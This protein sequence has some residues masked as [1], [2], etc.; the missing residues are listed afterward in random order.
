MAQGH[1]GPV[2]KIHDKQ[3]NLV[4]IKFINSR[5]RSRPKFHLL[6][7]FSSD[8]VE[9]FAVEEATT[10]SLEITIRFCWCRVSFN[11]VV[12]ESSSLEGQWAL[13]CTVFVGVIYFSCKTNWNYMNQLKLLSVRCRFRFKLAIVS[14][15]WMSLKCW[16]HFK[17]AI[18][19]LKALLQNY[20]QPKFDFVLGSKSLS[21]HSLGWLP[22]SLYRHLLS[23]P[24]Q[25]LRDC[26]LLP[27]ILSPICCCGVKLLLNELSFRST[28]VL[29]FSANF[30]FEGKCLS[31]INTYNNGNTKLKEPFVVGH[32]LFLAGYSGSPLSS[33]SS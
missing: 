28:K 26:W 8:Q 14:V 30:N 23:F 19:N 31:T 33:G 24:V 12:V 13:I 17:I 10:L 15:K 29:H 4:I 25:L 11:F 2:F 5:N 21:F 9:L 16:L 18:Q 6:N 22:V 20:S 3:R 7:G 1:I 32:L 27:N